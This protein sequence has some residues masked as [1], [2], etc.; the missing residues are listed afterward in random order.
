MVNAE[1]G[2]SNHIGAEF[3]DGYLAYFLKVNR[4]GGIF[5]RQIR[6][7]D[8]DDHY[9]PLE[10]IL[11]TE[12]LINANRVF[13]LAGY[14]G[15]AN[16]MAAISMV[17][18]AGLI[19]LGPMSGAEGLRNP[20]SPLV[21]NVRASYADELESMVKYLVDDLGLKKI[22]VVRQNDGFGDDGLKSLTRSLQRRQLQPITDCNF[23]RNSVDMQ[24]ALDQVVPT[25]PDA[26]IIMGTLRP[27]V[28]LLER[29]KS[30]SLHNTIF[31][32]LSSVSAHTLIEAAGK[33][34]EGMILSEVMP[35]PEDTSISLVKSFQA[36][37]RASCTNSFSH[38]GLEGYL[39]A[40]L[41]VN[42]MRQAGPDLTEQRCVEALN[43]T[44]LDLR[45]LRIVW[46]RSDHS[47]SHT[48]F[49]TQI[50]NGKLEPVETLQ[51]A[52]S[53]H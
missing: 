14:V 28:S 20:V 33:A 10:T 25:H 11:Y 40:M 4:E 16:S 27:I 1:T 18:E 50:K 49:L 45:P 37:M 30:T 29:A 48:V 51:R 43:Q 2:I 21:F 5:G 17:N 34:S 47:G 13:A 38:V 39:G 19:F 15:T 36:D 24:P 8:F 26:V 52:L 6:L 12:R 3:R 41:L 23:V 44:D 42:A 46:N 31:C 7:I 53:D 9:E 22:A 32:T 35:S